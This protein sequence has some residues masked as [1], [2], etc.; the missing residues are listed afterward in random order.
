MDEFKL[1][2]IDKYPPA[3]YFSLADPFVQKYYKYEYN[4]IESYLKLSILFAKR[5]DITAANIWQSNL[6]MLLFNNAKILNECGLINLV[7]R[8]RDDINNP[9]SSY[10][11]QRLD[12]SSHFIALPGDLSLLDYQLPETINI[13]KKLDNIAHANERVGGNVTDIYSRIITSMF[14]GAKNDWIL[15]SL[16]N[17][18]TNNTI[19][20]ATVADV[21]INHPYN[22]NI[23][24]KLI[25]ESN[26]LLLLANSI[27]NNSQI[28]YPINSLSI[29][30][31][32]PLLISYG[33]AKI[34]KFINLPFAELKKISFESLYIAYKTGIL[35]RI[36][37]NIWYIRSNPR[38][39]IINN[40]LRPILYID[41]QRLLN[42]NKNTNT[43]NLIN[44]APV[45]FKPDNKKIFYSNL[46]Q[47][48]KF[49]SEKNIIENN[50][51]SISVLMQEF[52]DKLDFEELKNLAV[53]IFGDYQ[54]FPYENKIAFIREFCLKCK[55]HDRLVE[56][57]KK[58]MKINPQIN[59]LY[60]DI[61][62]QLTDLEWK[63][64]NAM[65]IGE[66]ISNSNLESIIY[67]Y[68]RFQ[69]IGFLEKGF[70]I[71]KRI[72][73]IHSST[74]SATAFW[75]NESYIITN[76][77][78]L[79]NITKAGDTT[80]WLN[81]ETSSRNPSGSIES[82]PLDSNS[83]IVSE[84]YDLALCK[85]KYDFSNYL[86]IFP[87]IEIG[88]PEKNDIV[89]IIQHP[90][91]G[92]K[93][94]CIGHNSL[95]YIDKNIIQYQTDTMPGS[96]GAPV[97]NSHWQLIGIHRAGSNIA[98]P[99]SAGYYLY[100]EGIHINRILEFLEINGIELK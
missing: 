52:T 42:I 77:H 31:D 41:I 54:I 62:I 2:L 85:V 43:N 80:V 26:N 69:S 60:R 68:S 86:S 91:G 15:E 9:F 98:A 18:K 51:I 87:K 96:S 59:I 30:I 49:M 93:Q 25:I 17:H 8:K 47:S 97:F 6:S 94:I 11:K 74:F 99:R 12:E 29:Y 66:T 58:S 50:D 55:R 32:R 72:C 53:D 70:E 7:I 90:N 28:I 92:Q 19:S 67:N 39:I 1:E 75:V 45:Y 48:L 23:K 83:L 10:F 22:E 36:Q 73:M 84:K 3:I 20:R 79:P 21:I 88:Q 5:I 61:D 78:A 34:L 64:D 56:V 76:K 38:N 13:A 82:Y 40:I 71:S 46:N 14:S 24:H 4:T 44:N 63:G 100:N 35:S 81:Y 33:I 89:P 65:E 16:I 27:A 95:K 37:K 57:L